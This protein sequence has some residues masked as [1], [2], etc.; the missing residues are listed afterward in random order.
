MRIR[1]MTVLAAALIVLQAAGAF[2]GAQARIAGRVTDSDGQPIANA[3][4]TIT[5]ADV[6]AFEKVVETNKDGA[7]KVLI[8]DAT[9]R[10]LMHVEAKGY[11]AQ[12]RP[13]KVGVGST[14]TLFE[15]TLASIQEVQA[16]STA[17]ILDQPGYKEVGEAR[18]LY[19]AGDK[20]GALAKFKEAEAAMP[21]LLPAVAAVADLNL[22]LGRPEE[23]LAAA[24]RC[25][26]VD[27]ESVDCLAIAA[28]AANELGDEAARSEFM[29]RYREL[30]PDDPALLYNSA[31]V[32]LNKL[33]DESARPLL[34]QCIASDPEFALCHFEYGMLLLRLGDMEGARKHLETYLELAPDGSEAATATE[35]LK[36]L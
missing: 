25:L 29:A 2:A 30:N 27:D 10:Y 5:S 16:A 12:E 7:F 9:R 26:E 3:V 22:E 31:A 4:V 6:A 18:R 32:F 20:E 13:F 11:Q 21:D 8:L 28:N 14:D 17:E 1:T 15:F 36:Y 23:A 33:D 34:E 24:R 35:T 19:Q